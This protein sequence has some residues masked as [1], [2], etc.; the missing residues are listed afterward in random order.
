M[1]GMTDKK[2]NSIFREYKCPICGRKFIICSAI[3]YVYKLRA[4]NVY[5]YF[6]SWTCYRKYQKEHLKPKKIKGELW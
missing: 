2:L 4:K 6:C 5:K 1:S 3:D